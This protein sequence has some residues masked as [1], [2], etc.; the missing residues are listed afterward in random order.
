MTVYS[1]K[2]HSEYIA[3]TVFACVSSD[4]VTADKMYEEKFGVN[5]SK[6]A[7]IGCS[8]ISRYSYL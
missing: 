7:H 2:D 1:Y 6:Q 5:P 4:I 8:F 3:Y